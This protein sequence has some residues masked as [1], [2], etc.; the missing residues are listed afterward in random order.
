ML[1]EARR[2]LVS[3]PGVGVSALEV[4]H[5]GPWF[6]GV[7]EEAEANLRTLLAIPASHHVLFLPGRRHDA[8]LDGGR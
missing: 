2:D 6:T 7:I 8:V 3:L 5:R 1:E 4:S